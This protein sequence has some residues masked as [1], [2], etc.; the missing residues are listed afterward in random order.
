[1]NGSEQHDPMQQE[2]P[3]GS[4]GDNPPG[5]QARQDPPQMPP[6][7]DPSRGEWKRDR[8]NPFDAAR[9]S[10]ALASVLSAAPG[11]GQVYLGQYQRGFTHILV[12]A[13]IITMLGTGETGEMTPLLGIFLAFFWLYNIVDA[14]RRAAL[15]NLALDGTTGIKLPDQGASSG[16]GSI[17]AGVLMIAFGCVFLT[18]TLWDVSMAW[19][20]DWWPLGPI[21]F[22]IWLIVQSMQERAAR[23]TD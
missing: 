9:K 16:G 22:G 3:P 13:T 4:S 5:P 10:P 19:M 6:P 14:G 17:A 11:L 21:A 12:V 7:Y 18:H 15:Y 23:S 1:M 2:A 20:K 8:F